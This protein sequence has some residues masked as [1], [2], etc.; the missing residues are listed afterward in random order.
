M[1][2]R[3]TARLQLGLGGGPAAIAA[4][5]SGARPAPG[6]AACS[7]PGVLALVAGQGNRWM[8]AFS[9]PQPRA[10]DSIRMSASTKPGGTAPWWCWRAATASWPAARR[11]GARPARGAAACSPPSVLALV[12]GQSNRRMRVF[13]NPQQRARDSSRMPASTRPARRHGGAG[14]QCRVCA[15]CRRLRHQPHA[16]TFSG[17]Q[18]G[19]TASACH[20]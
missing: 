3:R 4:R 2:C 11:S 19:S 10:R 17:T 8:H 5:G 1:A 6:A 18:S 15:V 9:N 14:G 13:S 16:G 20:A 7:P 12:V